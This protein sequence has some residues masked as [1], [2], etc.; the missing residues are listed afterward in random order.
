MTGIT[1][2]KAKI[3]DA[4]RL[5]V[6]L[7]TVY[8]QTYAVQGITSEFANFITSK[9]DPERITRAINTCDEQFLVAYC[10]DNPIGIA[11]VI[12]DAV[13]PLRKRVIPELGKLYV[14]ERFFGK[15]VGHQLMNMVESTLRGRGFKELYLEVYKENPRA[16]F[17]YERQG[18]DKIGEV[19]FPLEDHVYR[20]FVMSK[21]IK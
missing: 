1:Y 15:G 2:S 11:E 16:I 4:L 6:L 10:N 18:F 17:F 5:S 20:N 3:Q 21:T 13:C 8:I 12:Y 7:K 14:L 9:F 19:D